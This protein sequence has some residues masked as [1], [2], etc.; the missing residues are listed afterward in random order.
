MVPPGRRPYRNLQRAYP[1]PA[2][3]IV[4]CSRSSD[5]AVAVTEAAPVQIEWRIVADRI[6]GRELLVNV[7]AK[8]WFFVAP[9]HS[10]TQFR[11]AGENFAEVVAKNGAFLDSKIC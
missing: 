6:F 11:R 7:D 8:A 3:E 10:I 9:E 4:I 2:A 5:A 1:R